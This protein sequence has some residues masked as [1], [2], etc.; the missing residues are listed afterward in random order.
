MKDLIRA[1]KGYLLFCAIILVVALVYATLG[2]GVVAH[3]Y[4]S[5]S[6]TELADKM[7][8]LV[9]AAV[10]VC[11]LLGKITFSPNK[12]NLVWAILIFTAILAFVYKLNPNLRVYSHHGF[13]HTSIV[14]QLLNGRI[15]PTNPLLAG[16]TLLYPWGYE[17]IVAA[18]SRMCNITPFY[19]F[20]VMNIVSLLVCMILIY[21]ISRLLIKDN[22]ANVLSVLVSIFAVTIGNKYLLGL[23]KHVG[24]SQAYKGVPAFVKFSNINGAPLGLVFYLLFLYAVVR[25]FTDTKSR[26]YMMIFFV[27]V[28][29]AGFIYPQFLPAIVAS[30]ACLCVVNV[31]FSRREGRMCYL[32]KSAMTV[33]ALAIGTLIIYCYVSS[34]S[35]GMAEGIKWFN[36]PHVLLN[37]ATYVIICFPLFVIIFLNRSSLAENV[38]RL[39]L[40]NIATVAVA[41]LGCYLFIHLMWNNEYKFSMLSMVTLGIV[42]GVAFRF[43]TVWRYRWIVFVLLLLFMFPS[44]SDIYT[45]LRHLD[46]FPFPYTEK[47]GYIYS[48]DAQENELYEWIRSNTTTADVF[49]DT[50]PLL[51]VFAQRPLFIAV[52]KQVRGRLVQYPGYSV[53]FGVFLEGMCGYERDLISTRNAIVYT[54]YDPARNLNSGQKNDLFASGQN[55]YVIARSK[56][57]GRGID[58]PGFVKVFQSGGGN[59]RVYRFTSDG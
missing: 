16:Q 59:F 53:L 47:A 35:S 36:L 20:A 24:I 56:M 8:F 32:K 3:I 52:D 13:L 22:N 7:V 51:P 30:T 29:G 21:A 54:I 2:R 44:F 41:T 55:V 18:I 57:V 46:S 39:V 49:I 38:D 12:T 37:T 48:K 6:H 15:P 40:A 9:L 23:L 25:I 45:N 1:N 5:E 28:I 17:L 27:S 26:R 31:V 19:T 33:A 11:F 4:E 34:I 43:M 14:Y 42:A 10:A 50:E 58:E